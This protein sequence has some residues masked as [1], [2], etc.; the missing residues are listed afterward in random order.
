MKKLII[1]N[2]LIL[3]SLSFT[4]C[5]HKKQIESREPAST[6]VPT[7]ADLFFE[8]IEKSPSAKY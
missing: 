3:I 6:A 8:E 5:A 4:G 7:E 1:I 2:A